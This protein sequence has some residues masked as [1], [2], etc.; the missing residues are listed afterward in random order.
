MCPLLALA[1]SP[2]LGADVLYGC[3]HSVKSRPAIFS[4]ACFAIVCKIP[5]IARALGLKAEA[6]RPSARAT[7]GYLVYKFRDPLKRLEKQSMHV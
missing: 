6:A 3:P 1:D 5:L 7:I 2:P 4:R